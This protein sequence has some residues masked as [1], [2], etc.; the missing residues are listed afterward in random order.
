MA[1]EQKRIRVSPE[2]AQIIEELRARRASEQAAAKPEEPDVE[3]IAGV[4]TEAPDPTEIE[5]TD[6]T[7]TYVWDP[8]A[9]VFAD[10][11]ILNSQINAVRQTIAATKLNME[12]AQRDLLEKNLAKHRNQYLDDLRAQTTVLETLIELRLAHGGAL[13]LPDLAEKEDVA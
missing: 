5:E 12:L 11:N 7:T 13:P 8:K 2:E 6:P 3:E 9:Q 1:E 10:T 4:A